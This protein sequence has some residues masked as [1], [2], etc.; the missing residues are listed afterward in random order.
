MDIIDGEQKICPELV[1][2]WSSKKDAGEETVYKGVVTVY[3]G[4]EYV[5]RGDQ[6]LKGFYLIGGWNPKGSFCKELPEGALFLVILW[7]WFSV[8]PFYD[9]TNRSTWSAHCCSA[10]R[11]SSAN[12]CR[13]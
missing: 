13:W 5:E 4:I 9:R 1:G 2:Y 6:T 10:A 3:P 11:F 7:E 12:S 8:L